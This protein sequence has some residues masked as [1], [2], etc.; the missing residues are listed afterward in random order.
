[1]LQSRYEPLHTPSVA[2]TR[3]ILVHQVVHLKPKNAVIRFL[4]SKQSLSYRGMELSF[5]IIK[6]FFIISQFQSLMIYAL[7]YKHW[8]LKKNNAK[9]SLRCLSLETKNCSDKWFCKYHSC[10]G[11]SQFGNQAFYSSSHPSMARSDSLQSLFG[12]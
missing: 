2:V 8:I 4:S 1:M 7:A 11:K 6:A 9:R 5:G 3:N 12:N 10:S